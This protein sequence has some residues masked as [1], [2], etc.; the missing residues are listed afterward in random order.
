MIQMPYDIELMNG[1]GEPQTFHIREAD[2]ND[3]DLF[4]E[5][6]DIIMDALPD[7]DIYAPFTEEETVDQLT[8][9][10]CWL[11]FA[12]NGDVAGVSVLK[13]NNRVVLASRSALT[14][15]LKQ[16]YTWCVCCM[17]PKLLC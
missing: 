12:E 13:P 17:K 15:K 10:C 5:L 16:D 1:R 8:N 9:D 7:K 4:M 2:I 14:I 3:Y 11:A 6:Q